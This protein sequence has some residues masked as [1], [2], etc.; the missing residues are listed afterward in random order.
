[1]VYTV[2]EEHKNFTANFMGQ[3]LSLNRYVARK[4][5]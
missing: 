5:L 3:R 1:L 2:V 4:W